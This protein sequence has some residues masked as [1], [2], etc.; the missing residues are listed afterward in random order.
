MK[1]KCCIEG[2]KKKI[3]IKK[4]QLCSPHYLRYQRTGYVGDVTIRPRKDLP[5][6]HLLLSKEK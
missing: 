3:F 5:A 1:E 2:C 4:H 6:F